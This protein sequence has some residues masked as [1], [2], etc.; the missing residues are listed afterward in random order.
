MPGRTPAPADLVIAA[1]LLPIESDADSR[2]L[3]FTDRAA[4]LFTAALAAHEGRTAF[5]GRVPTALTGR[6]AV[7]DA[8]L[9]PITLTDQQVADFAR[10]H[11]A[12][13]LAPAYDG[14]R[15]PV[16]R[17]AWREAYTEVNQIVANRIAAAAAVGA[18]VWLHDHHLQLVPSLL[19]DQRPD[20]RVGLQLHGPF[21]PLEL[22]LRLPDRQALVA[23]LLGAD[24]LAF[25]HHQHADN[26][27]QAAQYL[28]GVRA[29]RDHLQLPHR[30]VRLAVIPAGVDADAVRALALDPA[31]RE[32]AEQLRAELG[33]PET[34]FLAVGRLDHSQGIRQRLDAYARLLADRRLDPDRTVLVQAITSADRT[35]HHAQLRQEVERQVAQINGGYARIG[36]PVIH[37][38]H[39][40]LDQAE[41]VAHHLAA[42]V[43]LATPLSEGVNLTAKEFLAARID[44]TGRLVLSEFSATAAELPQAMLVNPYDVEALADAIVAAGSAARLPAAEVGDAR[45]AVEGQDARHRSRE[46]LAALG[47]A[48][49]P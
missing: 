1:G 45:R 23:G 36:R 49:A 9:H 3:R 29:G 16:F 32:R 43:F 15:Q 13:T 46:F 39:R 28:A 47:D 37:H 26:F 19:R 12:T 5:V 20:L 42:D 14:V 38:L 44:D 7:G 10:G 24:L 4:G 11:C 31:V 18:R 40:H 8:D 30:R 2:A 41:L 22:F 21:P 6:A 27:R 48:A 33:R 25:A 17:R 34:V 35:E